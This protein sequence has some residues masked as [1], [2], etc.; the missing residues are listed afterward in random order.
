[1]ARYAS[2]DDAAFAA[3]YDDLAPPR[4]PAR[5]VRAR[6]ARGALARRSRPGAR[7]HRGRGEAAGP[8][9]VRG[10]ARR[11]GRRAR[12]ERGAA[13]TALPPHLR[14]RVLEAARREPS[15]T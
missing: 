10:A 11:A 7:H 3:V 4:G 5:R 9:R 1:M 15:P 8:P 2:G 6:E 14:A 12:A 13:V